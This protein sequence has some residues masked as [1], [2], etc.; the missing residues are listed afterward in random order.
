MASDVVSVS[1]ATATV[2]SADTGSDTDAADS[3]E[4]TVRMVSTVKPPETEN[5]FA[6]I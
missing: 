4:D 6:F 3:T 2:D 5:A 1:E